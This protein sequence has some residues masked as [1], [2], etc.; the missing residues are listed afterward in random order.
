MAQDIILLQRDNLAV[1]Q[2]QIGTTD[3]GARYLEDH[4]LVLGD[5]RGRR[6]RRSEGARASYIFEARTGSLS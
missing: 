3:G 2:V 5:G 4:V 1:V 6:G